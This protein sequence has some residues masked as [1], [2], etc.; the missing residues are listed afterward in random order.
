VAAILGDLI[1]ANLAIVFEPTL[2]ITLSE[3]VAINN[4]T[5]SKTNKLNNKFNYNGIN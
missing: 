3:A 2:I 1:E 4:P 5:P